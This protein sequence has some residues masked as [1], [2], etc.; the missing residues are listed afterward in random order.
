LNVASSVPSF[1]TCTRRDEATPFTCVNAPPTYQPPVPSGSMA[2]I[3][4]LNSGQPDA[5]MPVASSWRTSEPVRGPTSVNRP[6][7]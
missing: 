5:F 1:L 6:P 7:M 2:R 3:V 4:P